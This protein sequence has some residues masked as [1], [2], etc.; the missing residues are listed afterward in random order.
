[1]HMEKFLTRSVALV[2]ASHRK[3]I[4]RFALLCESID[5]CVTGHTKHYVLVTDD[6]MSEFSRFGGANRIV[7]PGSKFLPKWLKLMPQ[8]LRRDGRRV[9][10][11]FRSGPV[12]GWHIQQ[13]LKIFVAAHFPEDR[14][15]IID[16]DNVFFRPFDASAYACGDQTPLY[17]EREAIAADAPLHAM[18]TRNCDKLLGQSPTQFPADDYIGNAIVWDKRSVRSMIRAI[19]A[20]AGRSWVEALCRTRAFSE[21]LLYG[22]FVRNSPAQFAA[23]MIV[24]ESL[25]S[26]YWDRTPLDAAAIASMVEK[27]AMAKVALCVAS[28]SNTPVV[29]IRKAV[30]DTTAV[31]A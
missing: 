15:C 30:R 10:W 2:T 17:T 31:L 22:H 6:C 21:Y 19:E 4:E 11:S 12:H 7:L 29:T 14:Y 8:L 1:M 26:A 18:W 13:L 20:T 5:R 16:S 28:I 25:T 3:D 24:A 9:W 27:S 23:H